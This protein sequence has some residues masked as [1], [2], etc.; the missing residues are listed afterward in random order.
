VRERDR[1]QRLR[2]R[3]CLALAMLALLAGVA[4]ALSG[5]APRRSGTNGVLPDSTTTAVGKGSSFCQPGQ[6]LPADTASLRLSAAPGSAQAPGLLVTLRRH[7][8]VLARSRVAPGWQG[9]ELTAPIAR[10][11]RE[12][13]DVDVCVTVLTDGAV[14]LEQGEPAAGGSPIVLDGRPGEGALLIDDY[15]PGR[16]TWWSYAPTIARR[17]GFGRGGWGGSWLAGLIAVLVLAAV[18][19]AVRVLLRTVAIDEPEHVRRPVTTRARLARARAIL[20]RVPATARTLALIGFLNAAAWSLITPPFLVPDEIGHVSY[21]QQIGETGRPPVP[22]PTQQ[23][24]PE[25]Q[26]ATA[27][28][29]GDTSAPT[30]YHT[31]LMTPLD[32]RRL[33]RV[34]RAPL[35]R[36]GNGNAGDVDPEPPLYYALEA[37][38]YR[39]A[40]GG[41]L[42]ERM[43]LMRLLSAAMAAATALFTFLFVRECLPGHRWAWSVG[44]LG[45]AF[46]PMLGFVSGGVNP[47]ALLF[48]VSAALFLSLARAFRRGMTTR[49]AVA[50]GAVLGIGLVAKINFYGL[51]PGALVAMLLAARRGEGARGLHALRPVAL[52]AGVALVPY[53]LV[54]ALEALA[55][56][57]S[58]V[59]AHSAAGAHADHGGP[60]D[61]L[62]FLWQVYL[63]PLPG[64]LRSFSH[65]I[66]YSLWLRTFVGRF[67][68]VGIPFPEWTY[69]LAAAVLVLVV[70]LASRALASQRASLRRRAD[71]LTGYA[72][73]TAS[74]MALIA[75]VALRGWAPGIEAAAQGRYLLPLL[76]LLAALLALA[77][78]G[79]GAAAGRVAGTLL[80]VTAIGLSVF[81]QLVAIAGF[82]G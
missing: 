34:L 80:V 71:E 48:A 6:T 67:G 3:A 44:A 12:H 17:I 37:L 51:V 70:A 4:I 33:E 45:A 38:P 59:L 5:A 73:M 23:L 39:L 22:A 2:V 40:R 26:T 53:A 29:L 74:L 15:R 63:P 52:A 28:I 19:L 41:T 13:D 36:R 8:R 65:D 20:R 16:E 42:P 57:R 27:E 46:L 35:A 58:F 77:A 81:G 54:T 1:I 18:A 21:V 10:T 60:L 14:T 25:L 49:R 62:S 31:R 66:G 68:W 9:Q 76:A 79:A 43:A 69:Q 64:Q 32:E 47:D 55:W 82:Y 78:R 75:L 50:I 61:Q 7:G 56:N 11:T 72:L 24:S 30:L